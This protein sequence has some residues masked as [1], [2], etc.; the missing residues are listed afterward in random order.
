M[1]GNSDRRFIYSGLVLP[2]KISFSDSFIADFDILQLISYITIQFSANPVFI[3]YMAKTD[4]YLLAK[5]LIEA[6]SI[7]TLRD[8]LGIVDKTPLSLDIKTTPIRFNGLIDN[9]ENITSA[10]ALGLQRF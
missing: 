3:C 8:L 9:P 10:T 2:P 6:G 5:S 1:I 4:K 7:K